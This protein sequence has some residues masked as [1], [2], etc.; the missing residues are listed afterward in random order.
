MDKVICKNCQSYQDTIGCLGNQVLVFEE[1]LQ[2]PLEYHIDY[3]SG[4]KIYNDI[5]FKENKYKFCSI[6][7]KKGVCD[8]FSEKT[9]FNEYMAKFFLY[10]LLVSVIAIIIYLF[11]I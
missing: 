11:C 6:V 3:V 1:C 9:T 4:K 2:F 7:N 5:R 8:L 10:G